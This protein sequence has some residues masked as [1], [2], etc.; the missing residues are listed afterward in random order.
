[1]TQIKMKI[2]CRGQNMEEFLHKFFKKGQFMT[3]DLQHHKKKL[4]LI[5]RLR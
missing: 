1:M 4:F 3:M 2:K 5:V